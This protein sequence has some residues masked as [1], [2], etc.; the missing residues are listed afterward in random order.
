[1]NDAGEEERGERVTQEETMFGIWK[2][3]AEKRY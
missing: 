2:L 3:S 1:M